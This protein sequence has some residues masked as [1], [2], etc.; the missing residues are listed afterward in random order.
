MAWRLNREDADSEW[1]Y[2]LEHRVQVSPAFYLQPAI[3]YI[4]HP[5]GTG[6]MPNSTVMI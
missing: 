3:Q 6:N 4:V 5:G 1:V 2:E